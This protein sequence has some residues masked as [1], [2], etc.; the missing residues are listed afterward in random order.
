[1]HSLVPINEPGDFFAV[2]I[3]A[4]I[5]YYVGL[6]VARQEPQ[7]IQWAS[8]IGLGAFILYTFF[9][10]ETT[11]HVT[12]TDCLVASIHGLL[13]GAL[14][15]GLSMIV[16]AGSIQIFRPLAQAVETA[17]QRARWRKEAREHERR[18]LK[19]E[20]ER[21]RRDKEWE[22]TRPQREEAERR[23]QEED[24]RRQRQQKSASERRQEA[25]SQCEL[26][27]NLH[28]I[29]IKSRFSRAM[30]DD[31]IKKFMSDVEEPETVE[32]RGRELRDLL[33]KHYEQVGGRTQPTTV[34]Q[35]ANWFLN[36]KSRIASL[37][38]EDELREEHLIQLQMRYSELSQSIL[39]NI[40]P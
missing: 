30:F 1:M 40:H 20:D 2:V 8:R 4:A 12:A 37:P 15:L 10:I 29:D 33:Q 32:R 19:E 38:L 6:A 26:V 9:T 31:Y 36:E 22:R 35:L 7:A 34:E 18:R 39:E 21:R 11:R 13:V 17:Q 23:K 28:K 16:L 27:F 24:L 3:F 25:R 14:A 5:L